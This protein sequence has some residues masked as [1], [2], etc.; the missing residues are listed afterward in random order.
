MGKPKAFVRLPL[1]KES[2]S[3]FMKCRCRPLA[4]NPAAPSYL[5]SSIAS[6]RPHTD[7]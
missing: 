2:L 5:A 3:W 6:G 4:P 1:T 7:A